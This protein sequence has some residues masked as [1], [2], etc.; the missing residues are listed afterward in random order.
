MS[1]EEKDLKI[2][3]LTHLLAVRNFF[4][5]MNVVAKLFKLNNME[6]VIINTISLTKLSYTYTLI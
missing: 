1:D 3:L 5:Q 4:L 2:Y 6:Y